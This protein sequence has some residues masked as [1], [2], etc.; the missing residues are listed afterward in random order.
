MASMNCWCG[1]GLESNGAPEYDETTGRL[2]YPLHGRI[3]NK[4]AQEVHV[5][6]D[7]KE[8]EIQVRGVVEETRFHF[9]KLRMTSTISI[10]P[11]E[12]TFRVRDEIENLSNTDAE[13]QMLYHINFG[14]PLLGG[15][16]KVVAPFE[17][18]VPRSAHAASSL[19]TW[20]TYG[21]PNPGSSEQVYFLGMNG[22]EQGQTSVLLKNAESSKG[23]SVQYNV[24]E[25]PCFSLWKNT[26]GE[27][28]GYVTGLEPGTNYPN[29]RSFEGEH[30]RVVKLSPG[31]TTAFNLAL[32]VHPTAAEVAEAEQGIAA[33]NT[34]RQQSIE[35]E[36]NPKW[37]A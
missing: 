28:D 3:A 1:C 17:R 26:A 23:V 29:P 19:K 32:Q 25:L 14:M 7:L 20:D 2:K 27:R 16:S 21:P 6:F 37:C 11:H 15:A 9:L 18:L 4:P 33:L 35:S 36:P 30:G 24:R 13:M 31:G 10:R 5:S 12:S 22:D 34:G 8:Q